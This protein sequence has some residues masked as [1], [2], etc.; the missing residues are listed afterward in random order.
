M[1]LAYFDYNN[2][3]HR[4]TSN[5]WLNFIWLCSASNKGNT[6]DK[7]SKTSTSTRCSKLE[8]SLA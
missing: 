5:I 1:P 8:A 4:K 3:T 6:H 2:E 7:P